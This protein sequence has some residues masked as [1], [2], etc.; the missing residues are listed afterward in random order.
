[1][2]FIVVF[3]MVV[4]IS[5][6]VLLYLN[7]NLKPKKKTLDLAVDAITIT[8]GVVLFLYILGIAT[9]LEYFKEIDELSLFIA[10]FIGGISLISSVTDKYKNKNK[11]RK[12][13]TPKQNGKK[14]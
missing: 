2:R 5:F 13:I 7:R 4:L 14:H 12:H 11:V 6:F 9:N 1:M 3:I 10:L 8:S